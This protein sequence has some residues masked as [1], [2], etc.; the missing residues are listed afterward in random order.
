MTEAHAEKGNLAGEFADNV[1][2][3]AGI[4]RFAGTGG[5]HDA[6]RLF[7]TY[8]IDGDLVVAADFE[9]FTKLAE[10]LG[11]VVGERVV[12]IDE[13]NHVKTGRRSHGS[14]SPRPGD[15]VM[16]CQMPA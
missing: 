5:D 3:N 6:V 4:L 8:L 11:Q 15:A 12:V 7:G 9:F 14:L 13:Q 2:A 10:K 16:C 1:D